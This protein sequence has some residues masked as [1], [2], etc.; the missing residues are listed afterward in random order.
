[1]EGSSEGVDSSVE[2][3]REGVESVVDE[4]VGVEDVPTAEDVPVAEDEPLACEVSAVSE[5]EDTAKSSKKMQRR[6][7]MFLFS[8]INGPKYYRCFN[9]SSTIAENENILLKI[10]ILSRFQQTFLFRTKAGFPAKTTLLSSNDLV[11]TLPAPI[12]E[13][14]GTLTPLVTITD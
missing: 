3:S 14:E 8:F 7:E 1:M 13:F 6:I 12:I 2:G 4:S 5:Q 10:Y 11:T 9:G